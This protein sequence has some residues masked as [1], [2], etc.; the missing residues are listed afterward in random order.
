METAGKRRWS[1]VN[2]AHAHPMG[3]ARAGKRRWCYLTWRIRTE[4]DF[5]FDRCLLY[6]LHMSS[7][8]KPLANGAVIISPVGMELSW[9][10]PWPVSS[11]PVTHAHLMESAGKWRLCHLTW[12]LGTELDCSLTSVFCACK[13]HLYYMTWR[14]GSELH[15]SL[16]DAFSA[17]CSPADG[18]RWQTILMLTSREAW[19][20]LDSSLL[21]QVPP[22]TCCACPAHGRPGHAPQWR[23]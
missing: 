23:L 5:F 1:S 19:N 15:C 8:W 12:R 2:V 16:A 21:L 20:Q 3:A 18:N 10:V 14:L 22:C 9:I 13:W 6:L 7:W 11:G 17:C 4:L